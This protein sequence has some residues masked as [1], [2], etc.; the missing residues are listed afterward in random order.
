MRTPK[1]IVLPEMATVHDQER[2][3]P[4][5]TYPRVLPASL[6]KVSDPGRNQGGSLVL[7]G[8]ELLPA[9]DPLLNF[10]LETKDGRLQLQKPRAPTHNWDEL[11]VHT[12]AVQ[13]VI[14]TGE[15][16]LGFLSC[17]LTLS[18]TKAF[19]FW[20]LVLGDEGRGN[21]G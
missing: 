11:D 4:A 16:L 13:V 1:L 19:G 6:P 14:M 20:L 18:F 2:G 15:Y 10:E 12:W 5:R 7:P 9:P 17:L 21:G 3:P 8:L